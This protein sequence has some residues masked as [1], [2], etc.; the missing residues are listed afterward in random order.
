MAEA[1][2]D[3]LEMIDIA[4][5][6]RGAASFAPRT[7]DITGHQ[8]DNY[9]R[10][11]RLAGREQDETGISLFFPQKFLVP[12]RRSRSSFKFQSSHDGISHSSQT[13]PL[14]LTRAKKTTAECVHGARPFLSSSDGDSGGN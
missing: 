14:A 5:H 11:F 13:R 1:V 10:F 2:V 6:H 7:Q 4:H 12:S 9:P 3:P 8:F